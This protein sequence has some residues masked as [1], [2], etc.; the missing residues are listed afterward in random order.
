MLPSPSLLCLSHDKPL[1]WKTSCWSKGM[2]TFIRKLT[3]QEDGRLMFQ[4]KIIPQSKFSVLLYR[5]RKEGPRDANQWLSSTANS[6][7]PSVA[8]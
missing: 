1:N 5:G 7:S 6:C 3:D 8:H 2:M 4:K